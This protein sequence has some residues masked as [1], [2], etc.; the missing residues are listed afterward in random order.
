MGTRNKGGLIGGFDQL[1]APDAPTISVSSGSGELIVAFTNPSDVGGGAI[2]SYTATAIAS[3]EPIGATSATSPVT[4]T[5]LS[6]GTS[7]S[8]TGLAN[9]AF[10]ASPYSDASAASPQF[11]RAVFVGGYNQSSY[12]TTIDYITIATTGNASNFGNCTACSALTGGIGS[13]T[14]GVFGEDTSY[15]ADYQY[16][17]FAS[18]GNAANFGD[19]YAVNYDSGGIYFPAFFSN[20]T[21]GIVAGGYNFA[22][23]GSSK[24]YIE[25]ITIASL[26][27]GTDFGNLNTSTYTN[28]GFAS[29]TRGISTGGNN[30]QGGHN[31]INDIQYI[32]I[33]STGNATD[34]GDLTEQKS[35][36]SGA[37]SSTRGISA[38][39]YNG[40][41]N[42]DTIEYITIASTG[43]GT[44]FGNLIGTRRQSNGA[45]SNLRAVFG[46]GTGSRG[47]WEDEIDYVT[48]AST[49]NASDFGDLRYGR[50]SAGSS[51]S[52][53][54][55]LQ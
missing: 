35:Y 48:I 5:G 30:Y 9:N 18:T 3:G 42:Y 6:D 24:N 32:T 34:F 17:T 12:N 31:Y 22:G 19:L 49:G 15:Q 7:Y 21:R 29:P 38:G 1:R 11:D 39:G 55:G 2:T 16:I 41:S 28:A 20:A 13:T 53:H 23:G 46:G 37:S 36:L 40:T 47:T 14:R 54:G 52:N 4:I 26:G 51:S 50:Y 33:A 8:V 44:D 27:N 10:G 45:S 25:Y 43:N